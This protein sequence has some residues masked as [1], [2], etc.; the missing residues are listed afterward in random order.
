M[1]RRAMLKND[2][3]PCR[4]RKLYEIV[5][6]MNMVRQAFSVLCGK[7]LFT[8]ILLF[9]YPLP[10]FLTHCIIHLHLHIYTYIII[11][12]LLMRSPIVNRCMHIYDMPWLEFLFWLELNV[13]FLNFQILFINMYLIIME[14]RYIYV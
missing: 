7:E 14:I 6:E 1:F 3:V 9:S 4:V 8:S 10:W 13:Y 12:C 5:F 11:I 2:F